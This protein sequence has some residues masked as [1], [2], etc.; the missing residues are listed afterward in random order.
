MNTT[1]FRTVVM[2]ALALLAVAAVAVPGSAL[3]KKKSKKASITLVV[4]GGDFSGQIK[5]KKHPLC[6]ADRTV[7]VFHML[8]NTPNPSTD[9][10]GPMDTSDESGA[11]NTGN[12]GAYDG[13]YYAFTPATAGCKG[14]ISKVGVVTG[15]GG[16]EDQ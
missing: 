8:G 12:N 1:K 4:N 14:L 16:P 3:A 15:R 7:S 10:E 6:L 11:W 5:D 9:E 2:A 13:R